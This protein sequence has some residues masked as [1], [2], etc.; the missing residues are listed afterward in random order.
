MDIEDGVSEE[1]EESN[2]KIIRKC[3]E[4]IGMIVFPNHFTPF[5]MCH[6]GL[7][8]TEVVIILD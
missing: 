3:L 6:V 7:F 2:I 5:I 4:S 1:Y 8:E